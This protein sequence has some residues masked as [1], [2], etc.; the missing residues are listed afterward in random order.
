MKILQQSR[1]VLISGSETV[2]LEPRSLFIINL[3][4]VVYDLRISL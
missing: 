3:I 1:Q 4:V 2:K